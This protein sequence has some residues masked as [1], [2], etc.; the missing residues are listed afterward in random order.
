ML[1]FY[2]VTP[3]LIPPEIVS[4]SPSEASETATVLKSL[5]V[6]FS[7]FIRSDRFEDETFTIVDWGPDEA[8]GTEDDVSVNLTKF[9]ASP[10]GTEFVFQ[11]PPLIDGTYQLKINES[12]I[13][14]EWFNRLG[15]GTFVNTF[16]L[17]D[18]PPEVLSFLPDTQVPE[19]HRYHRHSVF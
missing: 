1:I 6:K 2:D 11:T 12:Q 8:F 3:E 15:E 18:T 14:D 13:A 17:L 5:S 10:D 7:A 4:V 9:N 16:T 19:G